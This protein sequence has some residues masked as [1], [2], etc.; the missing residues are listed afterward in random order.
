M[1]APPPR[2]RDPATR[3]EI[4]ANWLA[5]RALLALGIVWPGEE[6]GSA[7]TRSVRALRPPAAAGRDAPLVRHALAG[8]A[9]PVRTIHEITVARPACAHADPFGSPRPLTLP[10]HK[11]PQPAE[12]PRGRRTVAVRPRTP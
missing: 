8:R 5:L 2:R 4:V 7:G 6:A 10:P 11:R 1:T 12:S 3:G 9:P